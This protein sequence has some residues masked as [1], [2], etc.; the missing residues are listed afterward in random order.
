MICQ[1]RWHAAAAQ[2][3]AGSGPDAVVQP[4]QGGADDDSRLPVDTR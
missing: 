2:E 1:R 3:R 4:G